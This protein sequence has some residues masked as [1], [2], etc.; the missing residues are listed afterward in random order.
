MHI[1]LR[2]FF[3]PLA[4]APVD[5]ELNAGITGQQRRIRGPAKVPGHAPGGQ[6][7]RVSSGAKN[8]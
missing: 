6:S 2:L 1:T 8:S 3:D 4:L 7:L 5:E